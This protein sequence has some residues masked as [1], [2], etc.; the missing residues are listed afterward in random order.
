MSCASVS[1]VI[2][3]EIQVLLRRVQERLPDLV[4]LAIVAGVDDCDDKPGTLHVE[5]QLTTRPSFST[6]M[7]A[8]VMEAAAARVRSGKTQ[9]VPS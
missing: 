8:E 9:G 7:S 5:T 4:F 6:E 1:R 3:E 2:E